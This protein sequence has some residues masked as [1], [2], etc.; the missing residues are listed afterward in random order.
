MTQAQLQL[1]VLQARCELDRQELKAEIDGARA[2]VHERVQKVQNATPW[3]AL[4]APLA[5]LLFM[6]FFRGHRLAS[7]AAITGFV[8]KFRDL[9]PMVSSLVS[10]FRPKT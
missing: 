9:W 6:R 7:L 3:I 8:V 4:A 2:Q 1:R 5:G 10:A